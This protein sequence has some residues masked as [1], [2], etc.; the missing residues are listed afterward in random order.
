[1]AEYTVHSLPSCCGLLPAL[2]LLNSVAKGCNT[3]HF[4]TKMVSFCMLVCMGVGRKFSRG[5]HWWIFPKVFLRGPKVVKL[6][7]Y[8]SKLRE[9]Q[10]FAEICKFLPL[11]R[12]QYVCLR[13]IHAQKYRRNQL[14]PAFAQRDSFVSV[15]NN[16]ENN[17]LLDFCLSM[18]A[19][20]STFYE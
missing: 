12:H 20:F 14:F 1:M 17:L 6:G 2:V 19:V 4:F 5:D 16:V 10:F 9:Q 3:T 11:F 15:F 18:C 8:H 13:Y 7:F